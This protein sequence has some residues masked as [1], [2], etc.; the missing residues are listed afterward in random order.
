[1]YYAYTYVS[2]SGGTERFYLESTL[3]DVLD[4]VLAELKK[5]EPRCRIAESSRLPSGELC[6]VWVTKL[7]G[8]G[9]AIWVIKELCLKGWEPFASDAGSVGL[10]LRYD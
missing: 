1:M 6:A 2:G 5:L 4:W 8:L 3:P 9:V 7:N 10:R